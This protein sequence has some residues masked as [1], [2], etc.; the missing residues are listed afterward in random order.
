MSLRSAALFLCCSLLSAPALADG[1]K[2]AC[3][4]DVIHARTD[5]DGS[6]DAQLAGLAEDLKKPPFTSW[7]TFKLLDKSSASLAEGAS[8]PFNTPIGKA[9]SL[10]Y[11]GREQAKLKLTIEVPGEKSNT[12]SNVRLDDGGH[13]LLAG[14]KHQG[15]ILIY[16]VSCK[17]SP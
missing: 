14:I 11:A 16:A 10:T 4:I 6:V 3:T 17:S 15:G 1:G 2:A 9:G 7:K 5:G 13:L 12:R 8:A